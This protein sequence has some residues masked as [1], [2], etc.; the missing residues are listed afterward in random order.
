MFCNQCGAALRPDSRF[1]AVCGTVIQDNSGDVYVGLS[2]GD[3]V[4]N[5]HSDT[6]PGA[7]AAVKGIYIGEVIKFGWRTVT[8]RFDVIGVFAAGILIQIVVE[9]ILAFALRGGLAG[10]LSFVIRLLVSSVIGV[11]LLIP[12]PLTSAIFPARR[13]N[14]EKAGRRPGNMAEPDEAGIR[15]R[16]RHSHANVRSTTHR[17]GNTTNPC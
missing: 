4:A 14:P 12:S 16:L 6:V 7:S 17:R 11:G 2:G 8:Q 10:V 9:V 15:R 13:R 3:S 1:C 5:A